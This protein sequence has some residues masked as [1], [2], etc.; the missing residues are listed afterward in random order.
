[1]EVVCP[2]CEANNYVDCSARH[3]DDEDERFQSSCRKCDKNF[4]FQ[5]KVTYDYV[6]FKAPCLNGEPHEYH[7]TKTYPPE[8]ARMRCDYCDH[9]TPL[10][11]E[12][13]S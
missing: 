9:E 8:C 1:M 3:G 2:Y 7:K 4:V 12:A 10:P 11:D 5:V 13:K 6:G